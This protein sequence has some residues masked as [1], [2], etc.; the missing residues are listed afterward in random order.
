MLN[1]WYNLEGISGLKLAETLF[2]L[3]FCILSWEK[4]KFLNTQ[5]KNH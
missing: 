4:F 5:F 3:V 1:F 2:F